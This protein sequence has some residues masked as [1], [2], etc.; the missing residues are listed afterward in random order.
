MIWDFAGNVWERVKDTNSTNFGADAYF[1]Q[2]TAANHTATATV[3]GKNGNA[4]TLFGPASDF[5][6]LSSTPYGGLG[7]GYLSYSAG[8]ILHGNGWDGA[9]Q[10]GVFA[11]GLGNSTTYSNSIYGFRCVQHP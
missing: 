1:S 7:Y 6:G 11:V 4:K 8:A 5:T 9:D 10:S 2:V 3:G